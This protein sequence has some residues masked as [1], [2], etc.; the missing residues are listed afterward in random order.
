MFYFQLSIMFPFCVMPLVSGHFEIRK[1]KFCILSLHARSNTKIPHLQ[2]NPA[3]LSLCTEMLAATTC[4]LIHLTGILLTH[5]DASNTSPPCPTPSSHPHP[6]LSVCTHT[7]AKCDD[8]CKLWV[9]IC[10]LNTR[11]SLSYIF[12]VCI[13]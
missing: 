11:C 9:C 2:P 8:L 10:G 7:K 12:L 3:L 1:F 6:L 4:G 13:P 5:P